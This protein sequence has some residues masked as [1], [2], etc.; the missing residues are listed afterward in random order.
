MLPCV[1]VVVSTV[2]PSVSREKR[3]GEPPKKRQKLQNHECTVRAPISPTMSK[4][5]FSLIT[6]EKKSNLGSH[7]TA[8]AVLR[9]ETLP[10][11]PHTQNGQTRTLSRV[12]LVMKEERVRQPHRQLGVTV[13]VQTCVAK[14]LRVPLVVSTLHLVTVPAS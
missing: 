4:L 12:W 11:S 7:R 2:T 14:Y 13:R 9:L 8:T 3:H 6:T 1:R 10:V 5:P